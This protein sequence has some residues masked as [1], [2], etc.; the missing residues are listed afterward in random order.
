M[1]TVSDVEEEDPINEPVRETEREKVRR[2]WGDVE[3]NRR[4]LVLHSCMYHSPSFLHLPLP[5]P[6]PSPP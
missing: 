4:R 2:I 3:G 1:E 6:Y 5:P